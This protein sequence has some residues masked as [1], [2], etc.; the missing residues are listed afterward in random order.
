M[1]PSINNTPSSASSSA[2][3]NGAPTIIDGSAATST[4]AHSGPASGGFFSNRS[5][6]AGTFALVGIEVVILFFAIFLCRRRRRKK[7]MRS[8]V[9]RMDLPQSH[10]QSNP[11]SADSFEDHSHRGPPSLNGSRYDRGSKIGAEGDDT[12][13]GLAIQGF[14]KPQYY[15]DEEIYHETKYPPLARANPGTFMNHRFWDVDT[16]LHHHPYRTALQP[17]PYSRDTT[18]SAAITQSRTY[19]PLRSWRP[20]SQANSFSSTYPATLSVAEEDVSVHEL[21]ASMD[22]PSPK[23]TV[24][25]LQNNGRRANAT[26]LSSYGAPV[27]PGIYTMTSLHQKDG[28]GYTP[29]S[30]MRPSLHTPSPS[31]P[32]S[33]PPKSPLRRVMSTR[34]T[35]DVSFS[36]PP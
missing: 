18:S 35:L 13:N 9:G 36:T 26:R 30:P 6:V 17:P 3:R 10:T 11:S 23:T 29:V 31:C 19:F 7:Q 25:P 15:E 5:T 12:E 34:D 14:I 1:S 16:S 28:Q 24:L 27:G 4:E 32:P 2:S 22:I 21:P 33:I 20:L 8:W